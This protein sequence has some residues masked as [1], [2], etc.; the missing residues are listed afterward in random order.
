MKCEINQ[1][2]NKLDHVYRELVCSRTSSPV[3]DGPLFKSVATRVV[4]TNI[5][6]ES[7]A[8]V[9]PNVRDFLKSAQLDDIDI[10]FSK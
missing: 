2:H 9:E 5:D 6:T 4:T 3:S 1:T 8:T 10:L 7:V